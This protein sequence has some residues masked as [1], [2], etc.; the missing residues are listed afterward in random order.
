[1]SIQNAAVYHRHDYLIIGIA[2]LIPRGGS[3][4]RERLFRVNAA[5]VNAVAARVFSCGRKRV[6][7]IAAVLIVERIVV[8]RRGVINIVR[9]RLRYVLVL[10]EQPD[11]LSGVILVGRH[12]R[13]RQLVEVFA[14]GSAHGLS[15]L[16]D[17]F[18]LAENKRVLQHK[19][20]AEALFKDTYLFVGG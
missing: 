11:E 5:A 3:I 20:V 2:D 15:R 14:R 4:E 13:Y 18:V 19:I 17:G 1:M 16:A 9:L 10:F 7:Q 8:E 12:Q 6:I